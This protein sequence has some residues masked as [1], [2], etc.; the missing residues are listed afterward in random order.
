[1]A[2]APEDMIQNILGN[3]AAMEQIMGIVQSLKKEG[4]EE[5]EEKSSSPAELPFG[6]NNPEMLLKLSNAFGKIASEEDPRINLLM[7]IKPYLSEKR[8]QSAEQAMQI[9]KLSKMSSLFEEFKIL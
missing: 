7:A 5:K 4:I 1:M 8:L 9:L 3:P 2:N 6:L